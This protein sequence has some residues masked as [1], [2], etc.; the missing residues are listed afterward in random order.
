MDDLEALIRAARELRDAV[1]AF[2]GLTGMP[3]NEGSFTVNVPRSVRV[4]L[5]DG[6]EAVTRALGRWG[7]A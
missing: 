7:R 6:D 4:E 5:A 2:R 1:R 3:G